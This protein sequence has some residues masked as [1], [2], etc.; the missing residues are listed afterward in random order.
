MEKI[1]EYRR[2]FCNI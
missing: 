1:Q 2:N